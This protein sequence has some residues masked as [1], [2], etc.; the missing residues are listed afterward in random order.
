[1]GVEHGLGFGISQFR[2]LAGVQ[3]SALTVCLSFAHYALF[4][5]W[6]QILL[7]IVCCSLGHQGIRGLV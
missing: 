5:L 4:I 2:T 6:S 7:P 1:M 3:V